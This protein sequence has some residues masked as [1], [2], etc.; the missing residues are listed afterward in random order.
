MLQVQNSMAYEFYR[1]KYEPLNVN[2]FSG[3]DVACTAP[4][5]TTERVSIT[6]SCYMEAWEKFNHENRR[7]QEEERARYL[8][9]IWPHGGD[10]PI[11][12]GAQCSPHECVCKPCIQTLEEF[13]SGLLEFYKLSM[14]QAV[15]KEYVCDNIK[16]L[17]TRIKSHA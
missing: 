7:M 6:A 12:P 8:Y 10:S 15:H 4:S 2:Q 17:I 14:P 9:G 3:C 11:R 5:F 1:A 16:C 13:Y